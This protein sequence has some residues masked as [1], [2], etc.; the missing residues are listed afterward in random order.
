MECGNSR[1]I[2]AR[3]V[4]ARALAPAPGWQTA[5]IGQLRAVRSIAKRI[6]E[7]ERPSA[8]IVIQDTLLL[9]RFLVRWANRRG[10]PTVVIQWAFNFPQDYYDRLRALKAEVH[11]VPEKASRRSLGMYRAVQEIVDVDFDLVNSYGGGEALIHSR[12]WA[13]L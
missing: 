9:E 6:I 10:I 8:L 12:R 3:L 2:A 13:A 5:E 1:T 7:Q 4:G 11:S